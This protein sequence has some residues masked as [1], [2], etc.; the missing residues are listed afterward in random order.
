MKSALLAVVLGLSLTALTPLHAEEGKKKEFSEKQLAQH[1]KMR[2]CN[3]SA[4]DK[5]LKGDAR[6]AHMKD[7]LSSGGAEPAPKK[8]AKK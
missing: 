2:D 7:C 1:Q 4:K 3:A 6:K 8:P 5:G